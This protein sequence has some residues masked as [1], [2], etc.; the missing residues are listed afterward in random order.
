MK[1]HGKSLLITSFI[2]LGFSI[3]AII[4]F[5]KSYSISLSLIQHSESIV[6]YTAD[7]NQYHT[8][9]IVLYLLLLFAAISSIVVYS[10][11]KNFW[12]SYIA[13]IICIISMILIPSLPIIWPVFI[14][15][16]LMIYFSVRLSKNKKKSNTQEVLI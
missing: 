13:N 4:L 9:A 1:K 6:E 5:I 10:I 14:L 7:I 15:S 8:F 2:S 3:V 12:I 16:C 11:E